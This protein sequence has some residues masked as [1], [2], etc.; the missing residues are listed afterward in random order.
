MLTKSFAVILLLLA[1][2]PFTAPFQADTGD[3]HQI[4]SIEQ[5]SA[6]RQNADLRILTARRSPQPHRAGT[7]PTISEFTAALPSTPPAVLTSHTR[8]QASTEDDLVL[9][10]VLRL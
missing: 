8:R 6:I 7:L 1:L 4:A 9:A 10:T 2:S 3:E 5:L